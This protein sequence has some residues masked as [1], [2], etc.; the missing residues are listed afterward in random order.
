MRCYKKFRIHHWTSV[1]VVV[2]HKFLSRTSRGQLNTRRN[3]K[4]KITYEQRGGGCKRSGK[5]VAQPKGSG[6]DPEMVHLFFK[7][8][9]FLV[10]Y[11]MLFPA[12]PSKW[13]YPQKM[14]WSKKSPFFSRKYPLI[15]T[16]VVLSSKTR[17]TLDFPWDSRQFEGCVL[18]KNLSAS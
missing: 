13:H 8:N 6:Y 10:E 15:V 17:G 3:S 18:T 2:L 11:L 14:H 12:S 7:L 5:A 4:I 16:T 1:V 9:Y